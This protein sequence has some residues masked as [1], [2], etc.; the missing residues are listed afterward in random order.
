MK[1]DP[2]HTLSVSRAGISLPKDQAPDVRIER[3]PVIGPPLLAAGDF[4]PDEVGVP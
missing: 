3:D 1:S 2:V 4:P